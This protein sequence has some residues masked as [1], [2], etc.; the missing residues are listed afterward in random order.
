MLPCRKE[1]ALP[2][3]DAQGKRTFSLALAGQG[4]VGL[5]TGGQTLGHMGAA[6][7]IDVD[8]VGEHVGAVAHQTGFG[9]EGAGTRW[10][11]TG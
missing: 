5:E 9:L 11:W 10:W 4:H 3:K 1:S 2:V 7:V 6:A 8:V